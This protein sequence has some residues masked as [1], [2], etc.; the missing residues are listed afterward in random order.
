MKMTPEYNRVEH[1]NGMSLPN[2]KRQT[3]RQAEAFAKQVLE[4]Y[5]D[6]H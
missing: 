1:V 5:A 3:K 6:Q 4:R 2:Q